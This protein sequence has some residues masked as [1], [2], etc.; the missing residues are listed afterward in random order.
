MK[1]WKKRE[2]EKIK[3]NPVFRSGI[4]HEVFGRS[5][6]LFTMRSPAL[7]LTSSIK[8][9]L[10]C[11]EHAGGFEIC[12]HFISLLAFYFAPHTSC[13][14]L[15]ATYVSFI[16]ATHKCASNVPVNRSHCWGWGS[17]ASTWKVL[18]IWSFHS[19]FF[20]VVVAVFLCFTQ[21]HTH[22]SRSG[23][24]LADYSKCCTATESHLPSA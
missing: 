18:S 21:S 5:L 9:R 16:F 3:I 14:R 24:L 13:I 20:R 11:T 10:A 8:H 4:L 15:R 22:P 19:M 23:G 2:R 1:H 12:I 17:R 6:F 7:S